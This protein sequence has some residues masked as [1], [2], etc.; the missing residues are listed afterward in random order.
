MHVTGSVDCLSKGRLE[1]RH[2]VA[3]GLPP[4][5]FDIEHPTKGKGWRLRYVCLEGPEA[6]VYYR[7]RLK[8]SNVINLPC[9]L[10]TSPSPRD[11]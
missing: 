6:A 9:L 7:G 3:D 8:E 2:K 5:S 4:K 11:S 1:A 10:Y